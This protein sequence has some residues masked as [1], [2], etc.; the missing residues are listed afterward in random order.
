MGAL[1]GRGCS[2]D[3]KNMR[4]MKEKLEVKSL[5]KAG[6]GPWNVNADKLLRNRKVLKVKIID[7]KSG[8][9]SS[10][11]LEYYSKTLVGGQL[12]NGVKSSSRK[13]TYKDLVKR[14]GVF[15]C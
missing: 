5:I 7:Q 9:I 4:Y 6:L 10:M 1:E 12:N 11:L 14:S 2:P 13:S 8:I 3:G 15:E